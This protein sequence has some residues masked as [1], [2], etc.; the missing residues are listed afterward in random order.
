V[1]LAKN[2]PLPDGNKRAAYLCM[3]E[4]L[5]RNGRRLRRGPDYVDDAVTTIERV[6]AGELGDAELAE[7]IRGR[8]G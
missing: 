5:E 8:A 2:H 3:R 4:F 6:A 1:R 7:W